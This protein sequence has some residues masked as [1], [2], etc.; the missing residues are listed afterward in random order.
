[1][2]PFAW[3]CLLTFPRSPLADIAIGFF[4][5][6][7]PLT[8]CDKSPVSVSAA[9][10]AQR[11]IDTIKYSMQSHS[12][13]QRRHASSMV[14]ASSTDDISP[15]S[16]IARSV[17]IISSRIFPILQSFPSA[18]PV[19]IRVYQPSNYLQN[20]LTRRIQALALCGYIAYYIIPSA[21]TYRINHFDIHIPISPGAN[22]PD[23]FFPCFQNQQP[24]L[25]SSPSVL[26]HPKSSYQLTSQRLSVTD[27]PK[28]SKHCSS[29]MDPG[30]SVKLCHRCGRLHP[31][32]EHTRP[33]STAVFKW[34]SACRQRGRAVRFPLTTG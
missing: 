10:N 32:S 29:T 30:E 3:A 25:K 19:R 12:T 9:T 31:A 4:H 13:Y 28:K 14:G 24:Q 26:P 2:S 16:I 23:A 33:G 21:L 8:V 15:I 1:M 34:C 18:H 7:Y 27:P 22:I 5:L 6:D 11:S 20:L 17:Y